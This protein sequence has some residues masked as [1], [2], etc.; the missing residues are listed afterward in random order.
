MSSNRLYLA[1]LAL[2]LG[3]GGA[4]FYAARHVEVEVAWNAPAPSPDAY[5]PSYQVRDGD[6]LALAYVGSS[7]CGPSN[8]PSLPAA[9]EHIKQ[10]VQRQAE[11]QGVG[12][13]S[14]GIAKDWVVENG[15][16]HLRKYGRFDEVTTGRSWMNAGV[17]TYVFEDYPGA[18]ATPQ[19][20][21]VRRTVQTGPMRAVQPGEV[22]LRKVG[23]RE[24][25][26]WSDRGAP[27]PRAR[28]AVSS[29]P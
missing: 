4:G 21:L 9:V 27:V 1:V 12:F 19:V 14:V 22:L 13:T 26:G 17:L 20:L 2:V 25:T 16:A 6:E 5:V 28:P 18:A 15:L 29:N 11:A 3:G 8:R 7:S 23:T 10:A 24:I